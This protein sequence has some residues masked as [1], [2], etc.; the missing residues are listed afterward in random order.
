MKT[1]LSLL[2][3]LMLAGSSAAWAAGQ[4][5]V[6]APQGSA[7]LENVADLAQLVTQPALIDHVWWRGAAIAERGASAT[8]QRRYQQT[9]ADLRAWQA[10]SS[11]DRAAA[12][13]DV[14]RQLSAIRVAGRQ[15]VSL[16]PDWIRLHPEANRQLEG[17]YDL[18][19]SPQPNSVWIMGALQ[20]AGEVSWQ[21]G[22]TVRGYLAGHE[23]L[24]GA[25]NSYA[26][27]ISPAGETRRVPVAYWNHR[28]VEVAPG[29][30]IWL[31][32]SSWS[33]PGDGEDLN[34]RM[35]SIL[36][37]RVPQQ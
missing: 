28:H 11:G 2:A 7:T 14:L 35:I 26:T 18:W 17:R 33:L 19:L 20:G 1:T 25:E 16:D 12:I 9:L 8:A 3:G 32:F 4:V 27:L 22:Q 24:S 6:H 21:P 34:Q 29:S 36:T 5:T 31:G 30:V 10:Q 13:G 23:R 15:F 37:H